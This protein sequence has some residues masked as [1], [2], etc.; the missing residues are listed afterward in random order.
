MTSRYET[1]RLCCFHVDTHTWT[2]R[3]CARDLAWSS[4]HMTMDLVSPAQHLAR[5]ARWH[6][7]D[8]SS[9][10]GED[11][12]L[13]RFRFFSERCEFTTCKKRRLDFQRTIFNDF[14]ERWRIDVT[15]EISFHASLFLLLAIRL[16]NNK[17]KKS[18][19]FIK[20]EW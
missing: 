16:S 13:N 9:P 10:P 4:R 3:A 6:L 17:N 19:Y 18:V 2:E 20:V 1:W 15:S 14:F 12:V 5:F 11:H 8:H 7:G